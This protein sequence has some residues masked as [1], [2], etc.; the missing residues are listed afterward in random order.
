MIEDAL[1]KLADETMMMSS[2]AAMQETQSF[3]DI[4]EV[5]EDAVPEL[6]QALRDE[7]A[8]IPIIMLLYRITK[9]WPVAPE[10]GGNI[11][12]IVKNWLDWGD[13]R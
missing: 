1:I 9:E 11:K 4:I 13:A 2:P 5:G 3:K 10:D 7:K 12:V 6:L 8:L